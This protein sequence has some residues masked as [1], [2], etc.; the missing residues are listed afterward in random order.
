MIARKEQALGSQMTLSLT[1][2]QALRNFFGIIDP[3]KKTI[4]RFS[5]DYRT[6]IKKT[7]EEGR[8]TKFGDITSGKEKAVIRLK[9][10][11]SAHR[12]VSW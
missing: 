8:L 9:P 3:G 1:P 2:L 10:L 11:K 5:K 7:V 4:R 6:Y 12:K